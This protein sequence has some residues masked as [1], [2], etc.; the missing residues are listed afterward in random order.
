[1]GS[2]IRNDIKSRAEIVAAAAAE[3]ADAVDRG[4][5]FPA[6]AFSAARAQR[7]LGIQVPVE[8]GGDGASIA[9]TVNICYLLGRSCS[10]S[11]MIFAMHQIMVSI[12]VRHARN[13]AWH[14]RMLERIARERRRFAQ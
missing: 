5:R 13:S 11:G 14:E 8:L 12:L 6:E 1:M 4:A 10:S 2:A 7:L 3:H 9:E